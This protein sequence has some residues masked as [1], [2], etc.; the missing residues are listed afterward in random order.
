M[1]P[2][3]HVEYAERGKEYGT[4]FTVSLFCEYIYLEYVCIHVI[5]RVNQAEYVIHVLVVKPQE[6]VKICLTRRVP[7]R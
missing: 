2:T 3:L 5:Y 7:V 4:L 1:V 6:Y